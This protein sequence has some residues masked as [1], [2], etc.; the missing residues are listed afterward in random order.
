MH[1]LSKGKKV[2]KIILTLLVSLNTLCFAVNSP[3]VPPGGVRQPSPVKFPP[4]NVS[5][6]QALFSQLSSE[7][8]A[9]INKD[10]KKIIPILT[11]ISDFLDS[12]EKV[13]NEPMKMQQKN[14][15]F[16]QNYLQLKTGE[17][18]R[19]SMGPNV[20][21]S[22]PSLQSLFEMHGKLLAQLSDVSKTAYN[23][24]DV[25]L[26]SLPSLI[27]GLSPSRRN[28]LNL[29]IQKLTE[30]IQPKPAEPTNPAIPPMAPPMKDDLPAL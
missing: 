13:L 20:P 5:S 22:E 26:N 30:S 25:V 24:A 16:Y 23:K 10:L 21:A 1:H 27:G 18:R 4:A 2:K 11:N 17:A 7:S 12:F 15:A 6:L 14:I 29:I 8:I 9:E 19:G 28:F 3:V